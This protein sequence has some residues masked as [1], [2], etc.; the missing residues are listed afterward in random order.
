MKLTIYTQAVKYKWQ[1]DFELQYSI[2]ESE[3]DSHSCVITLQTQVV[4]IKEVE[5]DPKVLIDAEVSQL[6]QLKKD[7]TAKTQVAMN[8]FDEKIQS[9]L[10]IEDKS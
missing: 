2:F 1:N 8:L 10:C 6:K 7:L 3:S 5:L 9:L 4:E